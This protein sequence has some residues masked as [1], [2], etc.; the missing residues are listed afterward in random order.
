MKTPKQAVEKQSSVLR[1][2]W[3]LAYRYLG[4]RLQRF[5]PYFEDLSVSMQK[6]AFKISIQSY[7]SL[8]VLIS[9]V[10]L[11]VSSIIV[12]GLAL[13]AGAQ[14]LLAI[15]FGFGAGL[16]FG[17]AVFAIL[18]G[19]PS[20]LAISRRRRMNNE[21]PYVATH[22]SILASAGIPPTRMFKLL[23]DSRTTPEVASDSNEIVRDVE[24]LGNDIMTALELERARSPS[25]VFGDMLEGL[26]A[27]IRSG[28]NMKSYLQDA[29]H[30]IMDLKR[31]A[32]KQLIES[33][34][35]FA[36]IYISILIVFPLLM[37]VMFSVMS[38]IGGGIGG[39][40]VTVMMSFITYAIIPVCAVA[41]IVMLDS[42]VGED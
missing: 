22:M 33:L 9:G 3:L 31:I 26:V 19:L 24:V 23:E 8:M 41:V 4:V 15:L 39:L 1:A 37:I 25:T 17:V 11:I 5:L 7:L 32:S 2:P 29:T 20:L 27:T 28:G 14:I 13:Y 34:A 30:T 18:Y 38:L 35:T 10:S 12:G 6:G 21:L 42:L 36:E 16:L 40:S